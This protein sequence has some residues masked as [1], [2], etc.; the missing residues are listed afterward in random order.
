M[1]CRKETGII[2]HD[3]HFCGII[4]RLVEHSLLKLYKYVRIFFES[5][6]KVPVM[7]L[8]LRSGAI[9]PCGNL[10]PFLL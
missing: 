3:G 2:G 1:R 9:D 4:A 7:V 10:P 6:I 8:R 5:R